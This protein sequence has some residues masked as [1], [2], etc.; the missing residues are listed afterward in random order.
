MMAVIT[1]RSWHHSYVGLGLSPIVEFHGSCTRTQ[2]PSPKTHSSALATSCKAA[3]WPGFLGD[4]VRISPL[5]SSTRCSEK[6]P[7]PPCDGRRPA[8]SA[9]PAGHLW[10]SHP[11]VS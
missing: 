4:I 8:S 7:P 5:M 3:A 6:V 1:R 11:A 10:P 9:S 2:C